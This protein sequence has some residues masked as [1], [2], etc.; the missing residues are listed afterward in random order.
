MAMGR[1]KRERQGELWVEAGRLV[2]GPGHPFYRRLN[3]ILDRHGFDDRVEA[4][5]A[6]FYAETMGRPSLAPAVYF[7]MLLIGY[8]EGI[9]SERGIAWRVAD[10]ITLRE[11]LGYAPAMAR[12]NR[13]ARHRM[14]QNPPGRACKAKFKERASGPT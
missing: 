3:E 4:I 1:R 9:D 13:S 8:F 2:P 12:R 14:Q 6:R 7:R 5:S 10:S 11:F